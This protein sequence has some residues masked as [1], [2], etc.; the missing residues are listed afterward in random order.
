MHYTSTK[1]PAN[2]CEKS[3]VEL[4]H[5]S[6]GGS[7]LPQQA[8][9]SRMSPTFWRKFH[10]LPLCIKLKRLGRMQKGSGGC[11]YSWLCWGGSAADAGI[12][13]MR[14]GCHRA[15]DLSQAAPGKLADPL[16]MSKGIVLVS[17][18]G[19]RGRR[20]RMEATGMTYNVIVHSQAL[21]NE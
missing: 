4:N 7:K 14:R 18:T 1:G 2:T 3:L 13:G 19:T 9:Q 20:P 8:W 11:R 15:L 21:V 6:V 17:P 16:R 5:R 12:A 10:T